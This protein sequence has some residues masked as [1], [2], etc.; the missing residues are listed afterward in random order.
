MSETQILQQFKQQIIAFLDELI[1]QFPTEGDLILLRI[2]FNDQI[3][4]KEVI[5]VF[6]YRLLTVRDM[7]KNRDEHFFLDSNTIFG[8][9][10]TGKVNHFKKL[11]RSGRLDNDDKATIWRW[12]DAFVKIADKYSKFLSQTR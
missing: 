6:N 11:W 7:I 12:V 3:P 2:F 4:I 10:E 9:L 5:D 1:G 8:D